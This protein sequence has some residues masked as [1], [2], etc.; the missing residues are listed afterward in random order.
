M[1]FGLVMFAGVGYCGVMD[2]KITKSALEALC[3]NE[4]IALI[5]KEETASTNADALQMLRAG[6]PTPFVIFVNQQSAGTGRAGR[7]WE[8]DSAGN[9]YASF[10]FSPMIEPQKMANFTTWLG[11]KVCQ[12]LDDYFGV[13]AKVKWPNDIWVGDKKL[14]G[15]M[16]EVEMT[17]NEV[18]GV[19]FGVGLNVFDVPENLK[20]LATSLAES[21]PEEMQVDINCVAAELVKVVVRAAE[22]FF[23]DDYHGSLALLWQRY[24]MLLNKQI[25]AIFGNEEIVGIA[26][27]IDANGNLLLEPP[28]GPMIAF[29]AGD[30]NLIRKK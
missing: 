30:V 9:I 6:T 11:V 27:G 19:A 8:S 16:T 29:A 17:A 13:P 22:T 23:A 20:T 4:E 15:T 7:K 14:S 21:V 25:S 3:G 1:F 10:G 28:T 24:D 5:V 2:T 12:F 18:R 26:R